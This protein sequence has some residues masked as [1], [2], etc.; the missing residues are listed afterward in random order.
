[1]NSSPLTT[2]IADFEKSV[3]LAIF[4]RHHGEVLEHEKSARASFRSTCPMLSISATASAAVTR[5]HS[6]WRP[7][8]ATSPG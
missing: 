6:A 2:V 1:M 7:N 5:L 3:A 4:D 8:S